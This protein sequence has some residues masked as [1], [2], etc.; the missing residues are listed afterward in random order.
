MRLLRG[1]F[2]PGLL[3]WG[4]FFS[5]GCKKN[6][7]T[8]VV[9]TD[10][11]GA[12]WG[13]LTGSIELSASRVQ[14]GQPLIATVHPTQVVPFLWTCNN[15]PGFGHVTSADRMA[16][17]LFEQPGWHTVQ[18][19]SL[20]VDSTSVTDSSW[21]NVYV[22]DTIYQP[23]GP[24]QDTLSLA[25]DQVTL[26]PTL[27]SA[28]NLIFLAQTKNTYGCLSTLVYSITT[29][30]DGTGGIAIA[31]Q[32]VVGNGPSGCHAAENP[33]SEYLFCPSPTSQWAPGTYP[34][35]VLLNG[36]TYTGTLMVSADGYSI[37]WSY[38]SGVIITNSQ[39]KK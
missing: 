37:N 28:A 12:H 17:Y 23:V 32:E 5:S 27:D 33:A 29:G 1:I 26:T 25:G 4:L 2:I 18:V 15:L 22:S 36:V 30:S 9:T 3:L 8:P 38:T 6:P 35:S 31:F 16:M 19:A 7:T 11:I 13:A 39:L 20:G 34:L 10:P 24:A 14:L 21:I